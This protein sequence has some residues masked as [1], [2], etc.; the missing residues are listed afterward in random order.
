MFCCAF[1]FFFFF[2][3]DDV[4]FFC[5][6]RGKNR[7]NSVGFYS[8]V[9]NASV[10]CFK[11]RRGCVFV[12]LQALKKKMGHLLHFCFHEW[13]KPH[14]FLFK[15]VFFAYLERDTLLFSAKITVNQFDLIWFSF[16]CEIKYRYSL[17]FFS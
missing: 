6:F 15:K 3:Q 4:I 12:L 8:E 1:F 10:L 16:I 9:S 14:L 2:Y 7:W 5:E 17:Q 13:E 11:E